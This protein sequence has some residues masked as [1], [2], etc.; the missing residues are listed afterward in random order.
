M[1][2]RVQLTSRSETG[3]LP[4]AWTASEWNRTPES[5]HR[6]A[7]CATGWTVPTSLLTHITLTTATPRASA[8]S[9][10][11]LSTTPDA[12]TGSTISS[13]PRCFTACAAAST[14]SRISGRSGVLA[15]L[16][17]YVTRWV[18]EAAIYKLDGLHAKLE[19][20]V[21]FQRLGGV[22][23]LAVA[24]PDQR[25]VMRGLHVD[26]LVQILSG[27]VDLAGRLGAGEL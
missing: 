24:A 4:N 12:V 22:E 25:P 6:V 23:R 9:S 3:T 10:A 13:P 7:S 1:V 18:M 16:S 14:A 20:V 8:A 11:A 2:R 17:R 27:G 19:H 21:H 26:Q 15:A 5:Q